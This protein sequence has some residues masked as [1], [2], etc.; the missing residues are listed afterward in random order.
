MLILL[1]LL[2]LAI[3]VSWVAILTLILFQYILTAIGFYHYVFP[4][5]ETNFPYSIAEKLLF[6]IY[7][8]LTAIILL[9]QRK[10]PA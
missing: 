1:V 3:K 9:I 5:V 7:F 2:F 4:H 8:P 6:A 10:F